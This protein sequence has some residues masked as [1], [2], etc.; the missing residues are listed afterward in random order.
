MVKMHFSEPCVKRGGAVTGGCARG[1]LTQHLGWQLGIA[2][3]PGKVPQMLLV[4]IHYEQNSPSKII[5]KPALSQ[6]NP[7]HPRSHP[8]TFWE[9]LLEL[10]I[11]RNLFIN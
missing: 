1:T 11:S 5:L 7:F 2:K 4:L 10:R 3:Y 6:I 9:M 8:E